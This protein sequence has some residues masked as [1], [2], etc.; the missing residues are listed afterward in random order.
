MTV[1]NYT[2]TP[3]AIWTRWRIYP[4][5]INSGFGLK[6]FNKENVRQSEV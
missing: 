5:P 1:K 6:E 2:F 4:R 3:F